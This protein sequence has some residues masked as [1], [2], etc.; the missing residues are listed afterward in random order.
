M[1]FRNCISTTSGAANL[2]KVHLQDAEQDLHHSNSVMIC[3]PSRCL[4]LHLNVGNSSVI[5]TLQFAQTSETIYLH[6]RSKVH[7]I[8]MHRTL[9]RGVAEFFIHPNIFYSFIPNIFYSFVLFQGYRLT[10]FSKPVAGQQ[11][12]LPRISGFETLSCRIVKP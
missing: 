11:S 7:A 10:S 8:R 2:Q 4:L 12:S 5:A 6:L 9:E 1:L 3:F